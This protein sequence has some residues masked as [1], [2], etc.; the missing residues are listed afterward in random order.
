MLGL[1]LSSL[2]I[3]KTVAWL[4]DFRDS[5]SEWILCNPSNGIWWKRD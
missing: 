5:K 4:R 1:D 3:K 2:K